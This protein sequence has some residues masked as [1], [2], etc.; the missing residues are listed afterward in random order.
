MVTTMYNNNNK[1]VSSSSSSSSSN[2][3]KNNNNFIVLC[4]SHCFFFQFTDLSFSPIF[5]FALF[6]LPCFSHSYMLQFTGT[7]TSM[8]DL[9]MQCHFLIHPNQLMHSKSRTYK[10]VIFSKLY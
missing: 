8:Q 3:S 7:N 4:H 5:V 2:E 6:I 9:L 10:A 1:S